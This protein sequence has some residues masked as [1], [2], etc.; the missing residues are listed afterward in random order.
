MNNKTV[1][2]VVVSMF[3]TA[4]T[5]SSDVPAL[6]NEHG[7]NTQHLNLILDL[8]RMQLVPRK[9]KCVD[10]G[11]E[12]K[13]KVTVVGNDLQISP[14]DVTMKPKPKNPAWLSGTNSPDAGELKFTV[15]PDAELLKEYSYIIEVKGV[16]MLDPIVKVVR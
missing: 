4:C 13:M 8:N 7:C 9:A 1:L 3:V 12:Y 10:V 15:G 5:K 16:G 6:V 2:L 11:A 14:G